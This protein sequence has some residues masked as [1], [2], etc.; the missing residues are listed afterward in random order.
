MHSG[1]FTNA[2]GVPVTGIIGSPIDSP[3]GGIAQA[4]N[5]LPPWLYVPVLLH[6]QVYTAHP[7]F[8]AAR[9]GAIAMRRRINATGRIAFDL[10]LWEFER[11]H[12]M[13]VEMPYIIPD[14]RNIW[15]I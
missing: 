13:L 9:T 2:A 11:D 1:G 3:G 4:R 12:A 8:I 15:V 5:T 6:R 10:R 7:A 14:L